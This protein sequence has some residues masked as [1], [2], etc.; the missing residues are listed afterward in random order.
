MQSHGLGGGLDLFLKIETLDD[1]LPWVV[2]FGDQV[3][4]LEPEQLRAALRSW[5]ERVVRIH[6]RDSD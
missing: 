2:G 1:I 5:A 6:S 4:V 3:E